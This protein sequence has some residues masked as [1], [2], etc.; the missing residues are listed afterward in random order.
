MNQ[1]I[2]VSQGVQCSIIGLAVLL[3]LLIWPAG[4]FHKTEVSK[5]EE[6]ILSISDPISVEHNGTQMFLAEGEYLKAVELYVANDMRAETITFRVYDGAYQ[7]LWETFYVV[8]PEEEFPG[9][10]RIPIDMEMQEG[11]EYYYT[12]EGLTEDLLL[13]YEDTN[14]SVSFANGTYL[15]GGEE[16]PGINLII[17]YVYTQ[18]FSWWF[19][20][21]L[22]ILLLGLAFLGCRFTEKLFA[23]RWKKWNK[24]ISVQ[25]FLQR[26][27]D[28]L[29]AVGTVAALF[30]VYPKKMFG[31]GAVNYGFY[32]LGI[33]ITAAALWGFL[34]Y[35]RQS[36]EPLMT[37][38]RIWQEAPQWLMAVA[39]AKVL[40]SCYEYING[41]YNIHH[42]YAACKMLTWFAVV[43]LCTFGKEYLVSIWNVVYGILALVWRYFYIKPYL[44]IEEQ[45][46]LYRLQSWV[47]LVGVFL[48]L[49]ILRSFFRLAG[50][51]EKPTAKVCVPY[52]LLLGGWMLLMLLFRN[53]RD[54]IVLMA[55]MFT[56]F[57]YCIWRWEQRDKL[58][59]IFCHGVILNFICM[60]GYCQWHRPY[61]RFRYNRYGMG[62]H[63]V[64]MTGYYLALVIAAILVKLLVQYKKTGRWVDCFKEWMLLGIAN[65]YLFLTLSRTGYLA[66]IVVQ[67]FVI[68][69]FIGIWEKK[70]IRTMLAVFALTAG[71][72]LAAFPVVFTAQ[73]ILPAIGN[74]PVYSEVEVW[75]YTIEKGEPKDSELYIDIRAFWKVMG[76]KLFGWELGNISAAAVKEEVLQKAEILYQTMTAPV[77][78]L[79]REYFLASDAQMYEK[80]DI[81][82]GRFDIFRTYV[83]YWNL[84]GHKEMGV[85]LA[86]GSIAV[87]A[88]NTFLQ[89]IHDNG[90]PAGVVFIFLGIVSFFG[91]VFRYRREKDRE[92]YL[93]LTAA[94]LLAFGAAGTVEWIF[95][96]CNFF[97]IAVF[98]VITPLLLQ[99]KEKGRITKSRNGDV[100]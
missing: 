10:I 72:S 68:A 60:A 73:R 1:K 61:H 69:F 82:N 59:S 90:L 17:R 9:F 91:A 45:E 24:E 64:T 55:V 50:K 14:A 36:M 44:G 19:T 96:I 52:A 79:S 66:A 94:V 28:P 54:W 63:T 81:S 26:I 8:D 5:S 62:F 7:Q 92:S 70:K 78:A 32:D 93:L 18:P 57:Y 34:H 38:Q 89:M 83:Q 37:R 85:P 67:L 11:W 86:D 87:H 65:A 51:K 58:L 42:S 29:L 16:M 20:G 97:G 3:F 12:V 6:E 33:V 56:V 80:E 49:Q 95:Q 41:L 15:Y 77:Y 100:G 27:F 35:K 75:E 13:Y 88:H 21:L 47:I 40:W 30:C 31:V 98:V 43:L 71:V 2:K 25:R 46:E 39:F 22:G 4:I 84:T 48:G 76:N 99:T 53:G 23:D 74:D